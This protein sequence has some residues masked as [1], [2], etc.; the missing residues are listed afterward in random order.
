[1]QTAISFKGGFIKYL[2][3]F[4]RRR[5]A[6]GH[7]GERERES[8]CCSVFTVCE[9]ANTLATV[10]LCADTI[11]KCLKESVLKSAP[12]CATRPVLYTIPCYPCRG[13]LR[14]C[15]FAISCFAFTS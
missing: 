12:L 1:M 2:I 11:C 5:S 10:R 13:L 15:A 4:T 8:E 14:L 7:Y 3:R 6:H 9:C